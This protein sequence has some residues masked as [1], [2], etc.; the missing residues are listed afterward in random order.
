MQWYYSRNRTQQGPVT[1]DELL[2]KLASG[3]VSPSDLVWKEGM[4][5]WI[6]ASQVRELAVTA[7]AE[8]TQTPYASP[9]A[10]PVPQ[11][12][13]GAPVP[14][15]GKATASMVLG[16]VAL[17]FAL[18]GCYGIMVTLPCG[19]LAI[20]FGDQIKKEAQGNPALAP[21]LGKAKAGVIMGWIG[22]GLGVV[23]TIF[24]FVFGIASGVLQE[25]NK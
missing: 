22:I 20:V 24:A 18:C 7:S 23:F 19:I 14:G 25:M 10:N 13:P 15:S 2:S 5:D 3:E 16:I 4:A 1:R 17:V 9:A 6:P 8:T 11:A 21:D 12:Y